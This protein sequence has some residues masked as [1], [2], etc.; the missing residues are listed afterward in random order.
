MASFIYAPKD[1]KLVTKYSQQ[2]KMIAK[3]R[4]TIQR[5]VDRNSN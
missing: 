3:N 5:K 4:S 2:S 1:K